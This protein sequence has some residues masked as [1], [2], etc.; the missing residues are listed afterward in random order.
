[1]GATVNASMLQVLSPGLWSS[2]SSWWGPARIACPG[3]P[4]GLTK[5]HGKH[6]FLGGRPSEIVPGIITTEQGPSQGVTS[7]FI[8]TRALWEHP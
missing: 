8:P 3:P 7:A 1:M 6:P 5:V 4:G 2:V